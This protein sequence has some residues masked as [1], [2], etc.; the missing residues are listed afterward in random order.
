MHLIVIHKNNGFSNRGSG[1]L[2]FALCSE[3]TAGIVFDGLTSSGIVKGNDNTIIAVPRQWPVQ[4][5][6][7]LPQ[8]S[9][10]DGDFTKLP[11]TTAKNG[12]NCWLIISNGRFVTSVDRQWLSSIL[13]NFDDDFIAVNIESGLQSYHERVRIT[14]LGD[15]AG[16]RRLYSNSVSPGV[17]ADDW[18][19]HIFVKHNALYKILV[20]G[21]LPLTFAEF[22]GRCKA[23]S[24]NWHC[25]KIGG[26]VLDLETEVGLLNFLATRM[27]SI[28]HHRRLIN[29][30]CYSRASH[31]DNCTISSN[32]RIFGKVILG[33][34][35]QIGDN[36]I[37]VGLAILGDN[38]KI[39]AAATIRNSVVAPN[40][41]VPK[42]SLLQNQILI[43]LE[44]KC[45]SSPSRKTSIGRF[46]STNYF[47]HETA[48]TKNNFRTWPRFSYALYPKRVFDIIA[49]LIVLI[50]FAPV[51]PIIAVVIKLSSSG[52]V[53]FRHKREGLHGKKFYCLKFRTMIVEADKIQ[54]RLR[55]KNQADGPQFKVKDDP[56]V[57][58][59]GRFLRD[60]FIDEIPQF[61]NIL[62]GQMSMIGPRPSPKSENSLCPLWRDA[63]LS[64]RPGITG[65][66]QIRR[67]RR[68]GRDFQ[69]WIYYDIKYVRN[70]SLGMDLAICWQT[71]KKLAISFIKQF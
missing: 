48:A 64:V 28:R 57:T 42:N 40:L 34:N 45:K 71:V 67:T 52:P 4:S 37:V 63:R 15:V 9:Q 65:L 68:P 41:S 3:L 49:T 12:A 60:T 58:V 13:A 69:E 66:W 70:I 55:F 23:N 6:P 8:I 11:N 43:K 56:R 59:V 7:R 24:L 29:A 16:F 47:A 18:P 1:L 46:N 25:L 27:H 19:H 33:K 36:A 32:A 44:L 22:I 51:L 39:A 5:P 61:F 38:V 10:Y 30:H 20:N 14:S 35:V 17:L 31:L 2:R 50:L 53:F 21:A 54:E 26:T 62:L